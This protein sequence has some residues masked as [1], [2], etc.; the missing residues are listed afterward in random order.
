MMG[1]VLDRIKGLAGRKVTPSGM[2]DLV[3]I[4][5]L[6]IAIVLTAA[7]LI[8]KVPTAVKYILLVLAVIAAGFDLCFEAVE[9]VMRKDFVAAPVLVLIAAVG[10]ILLGY[11]VDGAVA[12][13][14]YQ[15]CMA[16]LRFAE[17]RTMDSAMDLVRGEEADRAARMQELI[18][19]EG[20]GE[21]DLGSVIGRSVSLVLKAAIVL[22]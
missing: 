5:R 18:H 19:A 10:S 7:S 15:V 21:T 12:V 20:A 8:I 14:L 2:P 9:A 22:R 16:A 6:V 17:A 4:I 1:Q 13:I 3:L 11:P